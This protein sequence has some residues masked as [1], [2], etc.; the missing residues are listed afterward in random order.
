MR[1]QRP[2][3]KYRIDIQLARAHGR[4]VLLHASSYDVTPGRHK[5]DKPLDR[6]RIWIYRWNDVSLR[7]RLP[8]GCTQQW[9]RRAMVQEELL[10]QVCTVTVACGCLDYL[11]CSLQSDKDQAGAG[12][13]NQAHLKSSQPDIS[14]A[15]QK[16]ISP[17]PWEK[18]KSPT[19]KLAPST[20]TGK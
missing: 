12:W 15:P 3:L 20:N 10:H 7:V 6:A 1:L 14:I 13:I 19:L 16:E 9:P 17:S 5:C 2:D 4:Q 8:S 18:C 11:N